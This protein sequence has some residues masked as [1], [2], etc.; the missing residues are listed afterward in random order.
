MRPP[1]HTCPAIDRAL[2]R[3]KSSQ[4]YCRKLVKEDSFDGE[5]RVLIQKLNS[6]LADLAETLEA[7]RADNTRLRAL[8]GKGK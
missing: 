3:V 6:D 5:P 1:A 4:R 7:V 8:G 2:R